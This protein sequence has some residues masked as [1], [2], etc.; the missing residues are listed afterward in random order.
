MGGKGDVFNLIEEIIDA[1]V[2][3]DHELIPGLALNAIG[4]AAAITDALLALGEGSGLDDLVGGPLDR[5]PLALASSRLEKL[6]DG[7][8]LDLWREII[9]SWV[10]A[11]HVRWSVARSGDETQRLRLAVDEGGWVRLRSKLSGPFRPTPDR[12]YTALALSENCGLLKRTPEK[13][14]RFALM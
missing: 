4:I 8:M 3:G 5:L 10:L 13:N 12:L 9:E 14:P 2:E 1:Q 7:P 6:S 11:Q